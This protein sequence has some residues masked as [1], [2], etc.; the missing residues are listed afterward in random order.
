MAL[1][2]GSIAGGVARYVVSNGVAQIW[3][4]G[5]PYGTFLVNAVG[6]FLVGIFAV[7]SETKWSMAPEARLLLITGFCGAFTTFSAFILESSILLRQGDYT[8]LG[9]YVAISLVLGFAL[10]RLGEALALRV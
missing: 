2:G 9:L 8:R 10:F 6:C 5:F 1:I 4:T 3:G 7:W